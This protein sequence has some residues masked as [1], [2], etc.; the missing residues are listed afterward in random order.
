[1]DDFSRQRI[2]FIEVLPVLYQRIPSVSQILVLWAIV[3]ALLGLQHMLASHGYESLRLDRDSL[4]AKLNHALEELSG[5]TI[6][7]SK[8]RLV[9]ISDDTMELNDVG[10]YGDLL[11]LAKH[12]SPQVWFT[13]IMIDKENEKVMLEGE[14][15]STQA[16][17]DLY[18][19]L[20]ALPQ[21]SGY[22]LNLRD[23]KR[24][25]RVDNKDLVLHS[26]AITNMQKNRRRSR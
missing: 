16:L 13:R 14:A 23:I 25:T 19:T 4:T 11:A 24:T 9:A 1:M 21:F 15:G 5:E 17:N 22:D 18:S 20:V 26:F 2:N 12:H 6:P 10:F 7:Q 8:G 3:G